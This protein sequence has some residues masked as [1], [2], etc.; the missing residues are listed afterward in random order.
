MGAHQGALA[1]QQWVF[2]KATVVSALSG[3]FQQLSEKNREAKEILFFL[4]L[5]GPWGLGKERRVS[6]NYCCSK[7]CCFCD[8]LSLCSFDKSRGI[9]KMP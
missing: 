3:Y 1:E 5:S 8:D 9:F 6:D 4:R 2:A 7:E